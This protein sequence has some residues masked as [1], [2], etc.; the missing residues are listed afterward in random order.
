MHT[1]DTGLA[2]TG[3]DLTGTRSPGEVLDAVAAFAA[4][5]AGAARSCSATAGTS[6]PG[7]SR[8]PPSADELD[9][10]AGG[11]MVYLSQASIHSALCS[12]AL[13]AAVLGAGRAGV[14]RVRLAAPRRAPRGPRH[15]VRL[16]SPPVQRRA[17]QAPTLR[18]AASLGI[19]AVHECGGPGTSGETDFTDVL[20]LGGAAQ[21]QPRGVRV[22]GRADGGGE[23][24]RSWAR[25]GPAATCTP[26]ARSARRP[27]TCASRT[28]TVRRVL[29][30]RVRHRRAGRGAPGRL[31]PPRRAGRL[32]RHRRPGLATVLAGFA[33]GRRRWS[34]WT[35]CGRPAP[36][37][38]RGDRRQAIIAGLV[39]LGVV[40][41]MQPAFDRLWGG[42]PADVRAAPRAC[43]GRWRPTRSG[44][45]TGSGWRWRS[46]PTRR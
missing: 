43:R 18:T 22:L 13:L 29:R 3:L 16:A 44:R 38:A 2:L 42:E 17:A 14:R 34:A 8:R 5:A 45:C 9:R 21:R 25:S 37:R 32:P 15:R 6:R 11:R 7:P 28:W 20:A 35:G 40:A 39:E 27:P 12:T 10:A 33:G 31:R 30:P 26:T 19:A 41:S 4:D 24:A 1:T 23:G 46:A 36:H